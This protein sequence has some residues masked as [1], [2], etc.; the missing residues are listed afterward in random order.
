MLTLCSLALLS[1][2][3]AELQVSWTAPGSTTPVITTLTEVQPGLLPGLVVPA[4]DGSEYLV[5]LNLN[6]SGAEV[7]FDVEI[8][9]LR[10][11][12]RKGNL[13]AETLSRP[14]ITTTPGTPAEL[15]MGSRVPVAGT[16]PVEFQDFTLSLSLLYTDT[17]P[18]ASPPAL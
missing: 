8:Q 17:T 2:H 4:Q 3:A 15:R 9:Q 18:A 7:Q 6:P 10:A 1:A 14:R 16:N 11:K 5:Y 13:V 12:G